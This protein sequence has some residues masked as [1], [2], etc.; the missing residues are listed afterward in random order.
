VKYQDFVQSELFTKLA[1]VVKT[2]YP[3]YSGLTL[4]R[5]FREQMREKQIYKNIGSWW[6]TSK[7]KDTDQNEIDVVAIYADSPKVFIAEVKRQ[8]K[9][10]KPERFQQKVEAIRT[11]HF[12]KY[13][14]ETTCLTL[15]DM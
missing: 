1:D 12:F 15:E 5:Y 14:I 3:T 9:N 10:F 4:E 6:E 7:G 11:K 8:H 2:D 13:E